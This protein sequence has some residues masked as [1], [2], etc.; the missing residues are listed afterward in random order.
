MSWTNYHTHTRYCDGT[1]EPENYVKAAIQADVVKLG[2]SAHGPLSFENEWSIRNKFDLDA[3]CLEIR[4]LG[5]KY[6]DTIEINLA[7]EM[8]YIPGKT[9]KF[10]TIKKRLKLDYTLGS[11]HLVS[12]EN[13]DGYWFIDGPAKNFDNGLQKIFNFNIKEAVAHY[14]RQS[15]EMIDKEKPDII[16]HMDKIKMNNRGKY[17]LE[18]DPW[19][20]KLITELLTHIKEKGT[21]VEINTRGIYKN[22]FSGLFPDIWIIKY[23]VK[24][25]IPLMLNSD[26]HSPEE[27][28][29]YFR[30]TS[31]LLKYIG[32][33]TLTIRD[34]SAWQSV[35]FDE[36]GYQV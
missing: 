4:K 32:V 17:F 23:C 33:N 30:E 15:M 22:R 1:D 13:T 14:F 8:D 6:K 16:G 31:I 7:L 20:K 29:G 10:S 21:I 24:N 25:K 9:E 34:N 2:F 3:Y 26:A 28:T 12:K 19:Y 27:I 35:G 18:T 11:I 36:S 5:E